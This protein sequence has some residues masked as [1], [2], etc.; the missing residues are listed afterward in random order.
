MLRLGGFA[1][2]L[3][4][5]LDLPSPLQIFF[6]SLQSS[7]IYSKTYNYEWEWWNG[8]IRWC[9]VLFFSQIHRPLKAKT[10]KCAGKQ[11]A[12]KENEANC[13]QGGM[14]GHASTTTGRGSHH[15]QPGWLVP[16]PVPT[17]LKHCILV[18]FWTTGFCLGSS[19]LGL[20]GFFS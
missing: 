16:G 6:F 10:E 14:H 11:K 13:W 5:S 15:G 8:G 18:H 12:A 9:W 2:I 20:L 3:Q 17:L 1:W 19:V 7:L 4:C